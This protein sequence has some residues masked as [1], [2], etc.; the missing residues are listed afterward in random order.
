MNRAEVKSDSIQV[1]WDATCKKD[2]SIFRYGGKVAEISCNEETLYTPD[3]EGVYR[4]VASGA[5]G[6]ILGDVIVDYFLEKTRE[7]YKIFLNESIATCE[8]IKYIPYDSPYQD[9]A[10]F[11]NIDF[12][13]ECRELE[14]FHCIR[15]N[16]N[17]TVASKDKSIK[18]DKEEF[19]FSGYALNKDG[20]IFSEDVFKLSDSMFNM[21]GCYSK[22]E[23]TDNR[24]YIDSDYFGSH[25]IYYWS[26]GN[27]SIIS[28]HYHL[29]MRIL[30]SLS[31]CL[32]INKDYI[33]NSLS[34][35]A[36]INEYP[37]DD[38]SLFE[39]VKSLS[40]YS[41]IEISDGKFHILPSEM[42]KDFQ[43][44]PTDKADYTDML[45]SVSD[46]LCSKV[47]SV[48]SD[49][50]F[51]KFTTDLTGGVDS[52]T[53]L[54]A[55]SKTG[56]S[57]KV[58]YFNGAKPEDS[59]F[60][61]AVTLADVLG[62]DFDYEMLYGNS[63]ELFVSLMKKKISLFMHKSLDPHILYSQFNC[64]K[65][66]VSLNGGD[67][68]LR[69]S[70]LND[71]VFK[72]KDFIFD[73][74]KLREKMSSDDYLELK[75]NCGK[76]SIASQYFVDKMR[77]NY[78]SFVE[79][80]SGTDYE[81]IEKTYIQRARF[82]YSAI[83]N[84]GYGTLQ[85]SPLMNRNISKLF[86]EFF[87]EI[88]GFK[89]EFDLLFSLNPIIASH[90]YKNAQY[91]EYVLEKYG[92]FSKV[93]FPDKKNIESYIDGKQQ[94]IKNRSESINYEKKINGLINSNIKNKNSILK[95]WT[96]KLIHYISNTVG[97]EEVK[98]LLFYVWYFLCIKID[99]D[100]PDMHAWAVKNFFIRI[101]NIAYQLMDAE[102]VKS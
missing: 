5:D 86:Y 33:I 12:P 2:V 9:F 61:I 69:T 98:D 34:A 58:K 51:S 39:Q 8:K 21:D 16:E 87:G 57:N 73:Y 95:A 90:L 94:F 88:D 66:K 26:D 44:L 37:F 20:L 72:G 85:V 29:L 100:V 81:K 14:G 45:K 18:T 42:M 38:N 28:N 41:I 68:G 4:F 78:L 3:S 92:M 24:V 25:T 49:T 11:L 7:K 59:D 65:K 93:L 76:Y 80:Q 50:R 101:S 96:I 77:N 22:V 56:N 83:K 82:H 31:V 79:Q 55:I 1:F 13:S 36:G 53:V 43:T 60:S 19:V 89:T 71:I 35:F 6:I 32:T 67:V 54:A 102:F 70:Y 15:V 48:I 40:C 10:V 63:E 62:M 46:D 84:G 75:V 47:D 99:G 17:V 52:R 23:I 27:K 97:D 74:D 91:N 30:G 64:D